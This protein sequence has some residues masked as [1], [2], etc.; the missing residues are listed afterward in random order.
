[1]AGEGQLREQ[2][3]YQW[4]RLDA[5]G[6]KIMNKIH[7][8]PSAWEHHSPHNIRHLMDT[9]QTNNK[10]NFHN[11]EST[12]LHKTKTTVYTCRHNDNP[13]SDSKTVKHSQE[14]SPPSQ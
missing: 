5:K 11:R 9:N 4:N 10:H 2:A 3:K 1:M 6:H 12:H 14:A 7:Q 13:R 8:E